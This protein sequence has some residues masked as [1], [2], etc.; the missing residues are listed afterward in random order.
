MP[1]KQEHGHRLSDNVATAQH[2]GL[3]TLER[4]ALPFE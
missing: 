3:L 1:V 2:H 4:D